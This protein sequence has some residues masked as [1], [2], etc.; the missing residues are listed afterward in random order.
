MSFKIQRFV[1]TAK[2]RLVLALLR[3]E[4]WRREERSIY[5]ERGNFF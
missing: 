2:I 4:W 5:K 1:V 3:W